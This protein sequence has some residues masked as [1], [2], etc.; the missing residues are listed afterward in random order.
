MT[1]MSSGAPDFLD[2]PILMPGISSARRSRECCIGNSR[3]GKNV[4]SGIRLRENIDLQ[5]GLIPET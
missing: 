5:T 4:T 1:A 2:G 3:F